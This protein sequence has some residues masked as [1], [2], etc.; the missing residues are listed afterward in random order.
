[1]KFG[2]FHAC[3]FL[4]NPPP[5]KVMVF[6]CS[7]NGTSKN[8][9]FFFLLYFGFCQCKWALYI[10]TRSSTQPCNHDV[11]YLYAPESCQKIITYSMFYFHFHIIPKILFLLQLH[12]IIALHYHACAYYN[13]LIWF[14]SEIMIKMIIFSLESTQRD[15]VGWN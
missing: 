10:N 14:F 3:A 9:G 8:P 5:P 2:F 13:C 11:N 7:V 1:M 12:A 15:G 4:A 6:L